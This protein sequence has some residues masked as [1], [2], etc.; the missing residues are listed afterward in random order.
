MINTIMYMGDKKMSYKNEL[1]FTEKL[2]K[3]FR[4]KMQYITKDIENN[5]LST[6][7]VGLQTILNYE[8]SGSDLFSLLCEQCKPNTIY[9]IGNVLL[10]QYILFR[11]P[12]TKSPEF[13]YVGPYT[14]EAIKK[15]EILTIAEHYHIKPN[16][17]SQLEQFYLSLPLI[18]DENTLLTLI[19]T[20]GEYLWGN[21]D[22]FVVSDSINFPNISSHNNVPVLDMNLS[23]DTF[24]SAHIL[25]ERYTMENQLIKA[26]SSGKLHKAEMFFT[27]LSSEQFEKRLDNPIRDMKNYSIILNTI[28]RKAAE[29]ASVHPLHIH[30][31]SSTYAA[32]IELIS[33]QANFMSL[34][35]EMIRKYTLLVKN[36]SLKGY[37]MHIRKVI[38]AINQDLT[39]DLSLKTM[40]ETL[41]VNPSYLSTLFKKETGMTLTDYVNHKRIEHA[42]FLLNSTDTQ[43]QTIALYCGIPDVNYFTKVFKKIVGKTPKEYREMVSGK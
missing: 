3:N 22:N 2:L 28:L 40:A 23:D 6:N 34:L 42:L 10:C 43:I 31:I 35:K 20:L 19:Y 1:A 25:E 12:D 27:N 14:L 18:P 36:H 38:T 7:S 4:I 30:H 37:S 17:F 33:S 5:S 13:I 39:E 16:D 11:L 21:S 8:F 24:L 29:S 32:K 9:K 26:V 41:N 15:Q